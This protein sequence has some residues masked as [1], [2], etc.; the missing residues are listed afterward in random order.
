M[1]STE[2]AIATSTE[3]VGRLSKLTLSELGPD[4]WS[5]QGHVGE[6]SSLRHL[7]PLAPPV[8]TRHPIEGESSNMARGSDIWHKMEFPV[9]FGCLF[10]S[11]VGDADFFA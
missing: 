8:S 2:W 1:T 11:R 4:I 5:T 10:G 3:Q 6:A 7:G 9:G